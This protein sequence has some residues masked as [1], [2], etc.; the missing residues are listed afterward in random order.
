MKKSILILIVLLSAL[1]SASSALASLVRINQSNITPLASVITFSEFALNTV[2]PSYSFTGLP[3]LGNVNVNFGGNFQ[4]Q[5]VTAGFPVTLS[6]STPTGPLTLDPA[7]PVTFITTDSAN[8]TSPV[9]SGTPRFNGPVSV[10][11]S[12]PVAAVG[13]DGGFFDAVASMGIQAYDALGN[14]L[15]TVTNTTTGI[16]FF[17]LAD[18]SGQNIISGISFFITG[19]EPA[20]FAIDNLTFGSAEAVIID[21]NVPEPGTMALV[22]LGLAGLPFLRRRRGIAKA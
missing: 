2:N 14:V 5:G 11:F 1:V 20:G 22:G 3:D 15:G 6:P 10:L 16:E 18:N 21:G 9:L 12:V 7:G 8:P 13:L 17:G 4:G 19:N